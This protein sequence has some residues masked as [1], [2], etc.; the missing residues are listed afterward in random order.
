MYYDTMP[1]TRPSP[2]EEH[3]RSTHRLHIHYAHDRV[4]T[5]PM[6]SVTPHNARIRC[7]LYFS[8][9][10]LVRRHCQLMMRTALRL[11]NH[12]LTHA[13]SYALSAYQRIADGEAS[14]RV[15]YNATSTPSLAPLP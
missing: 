8:R 5:Y 1:F 14:L 2:L 13:A 11:T 12:R 10:A 7:L 9:L 6:G 3:C 4:L 15:R